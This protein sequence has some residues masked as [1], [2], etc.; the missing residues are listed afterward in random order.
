M[1]ARC[2]ITWRVVI[3]DCF[4]G[5]AGQ[6]FC[7]G[8]S[9]SSCP[10]SPSC[11]AAVAVSDLEMDARR[12]S[13]CSLAGALFSTSAKPKP[14]AHSYSPFSTTPIETPG[15]WVEAMNLETAASI[16]VRF[17]GESWCSWAWEYRPKAAH[18]RTAT[19]SDLWTRTGRSENFPLEVMSYLPIKFSI[20][21]QLRAAKPQGL[22][23]R[24]AAD[25]PL[26]LL[27]HV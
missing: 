3:G 14:L 27:R 8:A 10:R 2:P 25:P 20:V 17:S 16:W 4:C 11:I 5:K 12:K 23:A 18:N 9:R 26:A 21:G 15:T 19:T 6:Y 7:T 13:V 1:P 24:S 22:R